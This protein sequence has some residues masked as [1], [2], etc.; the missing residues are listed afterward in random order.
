M[1]MG[2]DTVSPERLHQWIQAKEWIN[3]LQFNLIVS[4]IFSIEYKPEIMMFFTLFCSLSHKLF[5]GFVLNFFFKYFK[6]LGILSQP[7]HNIE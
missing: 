1:V 5:V 3:S 2:R 7:N 6:W 4:Q